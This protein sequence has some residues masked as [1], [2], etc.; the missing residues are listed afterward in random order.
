MQFAAVIESRLVVVERIDFRVLVRLPV[1]VGE[2]KRIRVILVIVTDKA[3]RGV[4]AQKRPR[5]GYIRLFAR[6]MVLADDT[7]LRQPRNVGIQV[8]RQ[9]G[10]IGDGKPLHRLREDHHDVVARAHAEQF[11]VFRLVP[12]IKLRT[13]LP[14]RHL[15]RSEKRPRDELI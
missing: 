11:A 10:I 14:S 7:L 12:K 9:P 6:I 1:K 15:G 2:R 5:L 8:L 13:V 4:I 3:A